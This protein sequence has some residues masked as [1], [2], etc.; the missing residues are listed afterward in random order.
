MVRCGRC[1]GQHADARAVWACYGSEGADTRTEDVRAS[2]PHA[3]ASGRTSDAHVS[4]IQ[5]DRSQSGARV[6]DAAAYL[7]AGE[8]R[9]RETTLARAQERRDARERAES[10]R[11]QAEA[12]AHR[13]AAAE[14]EDLERQN[15]AQLRQRNLEVLRSRNRKVSCMCLT[16]QRTFVAPL[17]KDTRCRECGDASEIGFRCAA[18]GRYLPRLIAGRCSECSIARTVASEQAGPGAQGPPGVTAKSPDRRKKQWRGQ[19]PD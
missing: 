1:H 10:E 13:K 18:C 17:S 2:E 16:C 8:E 6:A 19:L 7:Q 15:R 3:K 11:R 14:R 12:A 5:P 9:A 4:A